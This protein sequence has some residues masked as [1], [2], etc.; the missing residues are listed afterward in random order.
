MQMPVVAPFSNPLQAVGVG[1]SVLGDRGATPLF[2]RWFGYASL[3]A[4]LIFTSGTLCVFFDSGPFAWNGLL[5]WYVPLGVYVI[6][7]PT[8]SVLALK[9]IRR[10]AAEGGP[11]SDTVTPALASAL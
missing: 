9:A 4:A 8:I 6:W 7:M 1:A 5:S 11:E 2:P 3:W 10:I